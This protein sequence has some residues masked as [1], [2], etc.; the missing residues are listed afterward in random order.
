MTY[1]HINELL[2]KLEQDSSISDIHISWAAPV[3]FRKIWEIAYLDEPDVTPEQMS[4]FLSQLLEAHPWGLDRFEKNREIDFNYFSAWWIPYRVNAYHKMERAWVAMRKIGNKPIPLDTLMYDDIAASV[5]TQVL[6][7]KTGIFLVTWPTWSG[8]TT[9]LIAMLEWINQHRKEHMV[10]IE[11]PIEFIFE[12]KECLISQRA[13]WSDTLSF[14][15]AMKAAMRQ[16]PDIIFVWEIRDRETA[17]AA[18]SLAETGHLVFSTLHTRS[19]ANTIYRMIS[20]FPPDVQESVKDRLSQSL[21][22]VQ[23]QF[24]LKTNDGKGR[25]WLYELM[26]N[27]TAIRNDIRKNEWKQINSIIETS[28]QSWMISH[29]EY[30]K[31]LIADWRIDKASVDW[32]FG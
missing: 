15:K 27:N 23:S 30:A 3:A 8:K 4:I 26:L 20:L 29:V 9:S 21:L 14:D 17:E 7:Q 13:Y 16:D 10:T 22:W 1:T 18:M 12:P 6:N 24:L 31:R 19:A 25:V 32:L 2:S 5:V 11:D 28:R